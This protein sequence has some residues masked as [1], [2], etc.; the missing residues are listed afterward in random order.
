M[1]QPM[2][3][4]TSAPLAR[5]RAWS[6]PLATDSLAKVAELRELHLDLRQNLVHVSNELP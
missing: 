4:S 6:R 2:G 5:P 1:T 3:D